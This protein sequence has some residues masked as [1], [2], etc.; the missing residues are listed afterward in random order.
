MN[1]SALLTVANLALAALI[2]GCGESVPQK[3]ARGGILAGTQVER[4]RYVTKRNP[5]LAGNGPQEVGQ[6]SSASLTPMT[7]RELHPTTSPSAAARTGGT[8]SSATATGT[9]TGATP[10]AGTTAAPE[11]ASAA[12]PRP[13][14][15]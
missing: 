1:K 7:P 2:V 4:Q 3:S 11:P 6:Q 14:Q 8:S 12:T 13:S 15:P 5:I 9:G 10:G